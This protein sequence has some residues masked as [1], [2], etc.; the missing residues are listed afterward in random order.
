MPSSHSWLVTRAIRDR[1]LQGLGQYQRSGQLGEETLTRM[2][3]ILGDEHPDTTR[4]A[5]SIA[6]VLANLGEHG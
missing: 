6:A 1:D 5:H 2:C 3:R 4:C